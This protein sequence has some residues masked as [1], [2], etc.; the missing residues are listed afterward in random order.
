MNLN[1]IKWNDPFSQFKHIMDRGESLMDY[2][3]D[4]DADFSRQ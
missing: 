1:N 4:I 3:G 2:D